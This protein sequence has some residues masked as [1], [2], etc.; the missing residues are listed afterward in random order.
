[1]LSPTVGAA[2]ISRSVM[3]WQFFSAIVLFPTPACSA[4]GPLPSAGVL[5]RS[6]S[7]RSASAGAPRAL[8][9]QR[10]EVLI[11]PVFGEATPGAGTQGVQLG[12]VALVGE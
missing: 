6:A 1:M 7:A 3:L 12:F 2:A 10:D 8:S 11:Q 5:S 4:R 9:H